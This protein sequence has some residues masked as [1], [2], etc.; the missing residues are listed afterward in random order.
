MRST[1]IL[2][3]VSLALILSI[4]CPAQFRRDVAEPA[5]PLGGALLLGG[6]G[7]MP[8][9]WQGSFRR[10]AGGDDAEIA[11]VGP[12][13]NDLQIDGAKRI[14]D[15]TEIP[16][17][18]R[19]VW[20]SSIAEVTPAERKA[21]L[22]VLTGGGVIGARG[23]TAERLLRT[24]AVRTG[25]R[26]TTGSR[27]PLVAPMILHTRLEKEGAEAALLAAVDGRKDAIG[28]GVESGTA[29]VIR[30]RI[31]RSL[32]P[33][34]T[35]AA[36]AEGGGRSRRVSKLGG[37]GALD[38]IALD[39]AADARRRAFPPAKPSAPRVE[40]GSLVLCGGGPLPGS[41]IRRF[42]ELAGGKD[43]PLVV[44]PCSSAKTIRRTPRPVRMLRGAGATDV[45]W[46]HTKDRHAADFDEE[47]LGPLRRARGIW[48]GG[49]RQ[50]N[51]VDS[52][53]HTKAHELMHAV[54]EKGGVIG[55][56]SAGASIQAEY[57]CRGNPLGNRDI[58]AEGYEE[59]LGFLNGIGVD[60]HFTQRGRQPDMES[61]V[62]A[63]P[64]FLGIGLDEGTA[65]IVRGS[66]GEVMGPSD[67]FVH[68]YDAS[69]PGERRQL[70]TVEPGSAY[71][72]VKRRPA[73]RKSIG[74]DEEGKK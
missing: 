17:T 33:G 57:M 72:L 23:E 20:V 74:K 12:L 62:A 11:V 37:R 51:F 26:P 25:E 29:L 53:Q 2:L 67:C 42:I 3:G 34:K 64:Q 16:S 47:I 69:K 36:L 8:V 22:R 44:I 48:L 60:Q 68:F 45:T 9:G 32:G 41:V 31:I 13:E 40:Q 39:R 71:D 14:G 66:I 1:T 46:I 10:L 7:D 55:G 4:V 19:G 56:S 50:W 28:F 27:M 35:I 5:S 24:L 15:P 49:G 59:G 38:L 58:M 43:A 63:Y 52:Y 65:L 30:N 21:F 61:F 18:A 54:L 6:G 70:S 73:P